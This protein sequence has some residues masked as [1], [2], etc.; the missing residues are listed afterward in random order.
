MSTG[1]D[2]HCLRQKK[3]EQRIRRQLIQA[4]SLAGGDAKN[5]A[6]RLGFKLGLAGVVYAHPH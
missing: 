3:R 2:M 5:W 4:F 1:K 6:L